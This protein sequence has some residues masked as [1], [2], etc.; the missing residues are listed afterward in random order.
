M[1][2][3]VKQDQRNVNIIDGYSSI[4]STDMD[5]LKVI[6]SAISDAKP[7]ADHLDKVINLANVIVQPVQAEDE[8][9]GEVEEYLRSVLIDDKGVAYSA[10]STGIKSSLENL[11]R[12]FG[13]PDTWAAPLAVKVTKK[14]SAKPGW[15]F[16]SIV[17]A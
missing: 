15:E 12:V 14:K 5:S 7:L 13:T 16:F 9:T 4:T 17:L 11:F 2:E 10:S 6:Y 3:I 1:S 8:K